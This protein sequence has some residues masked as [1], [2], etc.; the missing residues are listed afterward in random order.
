MSRIVSSASTHP[1][2]RHRVSRPSFL[3]TSLSLAI[4][5]TFSCVSLS[6][7]ALE[8][9]AD[10]KTVTVT[11][12][13][14]IVIVNGP[15]RS[16]STNR[17]VKHARLF[18]NVELAGPDGADTSDSPA[19]S[20]AEASGYT[21]D[22]QNV[23]TCP[24]YATE[25]QCPVGAA[26]LEHNG[27]I[28]ATTNNNTLRLS[29]SGGFN[30]PAGFKGAQ[31]YAS[32]IY[33]TDKTNTSDIAGT[34]TAQ[35]NRV[36]VENTNSSDMLALSAARIFAKSS[37]AQTG[38]IDAKLLDNSVEI[39]DGSWHI[40]NG[41]ISGGQAFVYGA[42]AVA[43]SVLSENNSVTINNI[44]QTADLWQVK[45]T[46][47]PFVSGIYGT[48]VVGWSGTTGT[49]SLVTRA[50]QVTING[51]RFDTLMDGIVGAVIGHGNNTTEITSENN[52]VTINGGT[53]T[54][55]RNIYGTNAT[56]GTLNTTLTGNQVIITDEKAVP[57]FIGRGDTS[58]TG[59]VLLAPTT[60]NIIG[61]FGWGPYGVKRGTVNASQNAVVLKAGES[62]SSSVFGAFLQVLS[63]EHTL[64]GN[65]VTIEGGTWDNLP[66]AMGA[67]SDYAQNKV[68]ANEN[69]VTITGGTINHPIT[70]VIGAYITD[71]QTPTTETQDVVAQKNEILIN[72]NVPVKLVVGAYTDGADLR[73]TN[74]TLTKNKV[75]LSQAPQLENASLYGALVPTSTIASAR[76]ADVFTGNTLVVDNYTGTGKLNTI[77]NFENYEFM[78]PATHVVNESIALKTATL[79]LDN[80]TNPEQHAWIQ[81]VGLYGEPRVL[82]A[83]DKIYLIEADTI[84]G[85]LANEGLTLMVDQG[86]TVSTRTLVHQEKNQIYLEVDK[87]RTN[88][89]LGGGVDPTT[90][91]DPGTTTTEPTTPAESTGTSD[92]AGEVSEV[93]PVAKTFSEGYLAGALAGVRAGDLV[94]G[95]AMI[96]SKLVK[97]R[98]ARW[99]GFGIASGIR[100]KYRTGSHIDTKDTSLIAGLLRG[101]QFDA[102]NLTLGVFFEAG[103][104]RYDTHNDVTEGGHGRGTV[105]Y[106]GGGALVRL[107]GHNGLYAEASV[108][109]GE[110]RNQFDSGLV[111]GLGRTS[112]YNVHANYFGFH[113]GA[114]YE[115][116]LNDKL[117]GEVYTKYLFTRLDGNDVTTTTGDLLS[118]DSVTSQRLRVGGRVAYQMTE[119]LSPYVGLGVEREFSAKSKATTFGLPISAPSLTGTSGMAEVGLKLL[120][121][122]GQ[123]GWSADVN[124]RGYFGTRQEIGGNVRVGYKF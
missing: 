43:V 13:H 52:V 16:I 93:K 89:G 82:K 3:R 96:E 101:V 72:A 92:N 22:I 94:A 26:R 118:F 102:A 77:A 24:R 114:G 121:P 51:G 11:E 2:S 76:S 80:P 85:T 83:G 47:S 14:T 6:A 86:V 99:K 50:N 49:A 33:I 20:A 100:G 5:S 91:T 116:Q 95:Q 4:L 54:D 103:R 56:T 78:L 84:N 15:D 109:A 45:S 8:L 69:K 41:S 36:I 124:L 62:A 87:P 74:I 1:Y 111:D 63:P 73:K 18:S 68:T 112:S 88:G 46:K 31:A 117:G 71:L 19:A 105:H 28:A 30:D 34:V 79:S 104:S 120:E 113:V 123:Y 32:Y 44:N 38:K 39:T 66:V 60:P 10:T 23:I 70:K 75:T 27:L 59:E 29:G 119:R 12:P 25:S 40:R 53:F 35:G 48:E 17:L 122:K 57:K 81:S 115:W 58:E 98:F 90:P 64:N 110:A 9:N 97:E 42:N 67:R 7:Y 21:L 107:D 108:R 37:G 55:V 106:T 65:T 61:A